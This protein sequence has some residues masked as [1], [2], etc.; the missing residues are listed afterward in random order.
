VPNSNTSREDSHATAARPSATDAKRATTEIQ[1][2]SVERKINGVPVSTTPKDHASTPV[3]SD[4]RR[5]VCKD[6]PC[7]EPAPKPVQPKPVVPEPPHKICKDGAC[8]ACPAGEVQGKD[9]SCAAA[10]RVV[11]NGSV[12]GARGAKN[13]VQQACAAG[14]VW[15]GAQC[16]VMGAQ[17]CGP[18]QTRVGASCQDCTIATAGTQNIIVRLRSARQDRDSACAQNPT[19]N[20]CQSA[21]TTYNMTLN[22]YRNVLG[23]VP[24]ECQTSLPDPSAI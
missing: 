13:A 10:P 3:E 24:I 9:G 23:G 18:G 15:N 21:E 2:G 22:E 8:K 1:P 4:L 19:G 16:V 20:E 6:G 14:Q 5:P 17:Q 11:K 12:T 7:Q